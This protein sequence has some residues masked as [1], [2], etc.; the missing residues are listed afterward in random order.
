MWMT[1]HADL[2]ID[3]ATARDEGLEHID[4]IAA[5]YAH[6]TGLDRDAMKDYL[7]KNISYTPDE[8]MLA[9]LELYFELAGKHGLIENKKPISANS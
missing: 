1:R 7:T 3:F 5:N 9:G 8:S 6:Q 4:E 2:D